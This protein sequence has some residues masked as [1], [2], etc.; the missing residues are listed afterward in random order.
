MKKLFGMAVLALG[1]VLAGAPAVMAGGSSDT[2]G[3]G[4]HC[5]LFF[6][7]PDGE[8][9]QA[10]VNDS[11]PDEVIKKAEEFMEKYEDGEGMEYVTAVGNIEDSV[12]AADHFLCYQAN[13]DIVCGD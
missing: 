5:Y 6:S 9:A 2:S 13:Q 10:I 7:L 11:D 4:Y 1:L 12:C 3:D 8:F